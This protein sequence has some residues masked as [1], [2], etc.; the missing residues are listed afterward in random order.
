MY[1][2]RMRSWAFFATS[3]L[4][5][6]RRVFVNNRDWR[7]VRALYWD[8]PALQNRPFAPQNVQKLLER[9]KKLSYARRGEA[10]EETD[11]YTATSTQRVRNEADEGFEPPYASRRPK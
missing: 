5:A 1:P 9:V 2:A 6:S 4:G 3:S 11:D 8:T 7:M 10:G